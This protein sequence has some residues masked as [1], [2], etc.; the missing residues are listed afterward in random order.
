MGGKSRSRYRRPRVNR[1]VQKA[2]RLSVSRPK[3]KCHLFRVVSDDGI[4]SRSILVSVIGCKSAKSL[5]VPD[6][7]DTS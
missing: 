1:V 5:A 7:A 4:D 2:E 3:C 6:S